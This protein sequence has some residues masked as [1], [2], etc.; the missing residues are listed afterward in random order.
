M[1][2]LET[3][4]RLLSEKLGID[5]GAASGGLSSLLGDGAGGLDLG[6]VVG[7]LGQGGLGD[8]VGS[9]LGDGDN[10]PVSPAALTDALGADR[11][12]AAAASMGID[13]DS[14]GNGLSD[15]LP[16]LI[17]RS[18]SGGSLL[19]AV[20]GEGGIADLAKRFF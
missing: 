3:A 7:A 1:E 2:L 16:D 12:A 9:W 14:L 17:D 6:A 19:D 10:A 13:A 4:A 5:E 15:L 18:S 8:I 11:L 20:A